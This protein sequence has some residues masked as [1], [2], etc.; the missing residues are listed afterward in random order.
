M[1]R[2]RRGETTYNYTAGS[3]GGDCAADGTITLLPGDVKTCTIT[4]TF[5]APKLTVQKLVNNAGGGTKQPGDFSLVVDGNPV[6]N[7]QQITTTVGPH[8][9][10]E[11]PDPNYTAVIGG[12]CAANGSITLAAGD[13]KNCTITNT[14]NSAPTA[15]RSS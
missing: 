8:T 4:N 9:V 5:K 15:T 12:D 2:T 14:F 13:V 10:S 6:T 1:A 7:N 11:T 3:I